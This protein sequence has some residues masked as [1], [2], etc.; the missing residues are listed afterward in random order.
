ML[1]RSSCRALLALLFTALP[2][3]T[4]SMAQSVQKQIA[5][6]LSYD[7]KTLDPAKVDD[8]ASEMVRY[9][10][11]GVL[12]RINRTTQQVEPSLAS[13]WT[14]SADG[15]LVTFYL[16]PGLRFSDGSP[17]TSEDVA[18]SLRRVLDPAT[19]APVAEEFL[20]PRQ[21]QVDTPDPLTVRVHLPQRV[22]T[23][24]RVFDEIA[25]EPANRPSSS[26]I[27]AGPFTLVD[28]K[29]GDFIRLQR[30]PFYWKHDAGGVA[31]PYLNA[32][33]LDI[34]SN[35]EQ[36]QLRFLRGRYQLIDGVTPENYAALAKARPQSMHDLGP[37]LNTEQMWFNQ[38]PGAPLPPWEKV[39]FQSRA[40]RVAVSRAIHRAD[41]ARIA[42]NGHAT[43]AN[44]F[45]SPAN[46]T[47]YD[48]HLQPI[49]QDT[50]GA[51]QMLAQAGF[52]KSGDHL[53]DRGGHP[54]K[55]SILTNAGNRA[56]ERMASMIQQDLA[57][58]GMQVNVVT[59]DFPALIE[60]LMHTQDYEAALLGLSNVDPDPS[61]MM[62]VW[63][64]SSPNHQWNPSEK[65][66]ATDW[67]AEID[68]QMQLQASSSDM[69]VRRKAVDRVQQIVYE[70][71][72]FLYLVYPNQLC[73]VTPEL[74][75]V[76]LSVLQP[77]IV[78][79]IDRMRWKGS[80]P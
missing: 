1:S 9:L 16:R 39:W 49:P 57:A 33:Q 11:G 72:P 55:F 44:G 2:C 30:N 66:P 24:G 73:A 46:A 61:A 48:S 25:I 70:Q 27:T 12:L 10:T 71:Q 80:K 29:R 40:F 18:F 56:R 20:S 54:V 75:G 4:L 22:V 64:S 79:N 60:R 8:Q 74:S 41:L 5:W 50:A 58:L 42:Y 35:R 62:N 3:C 13:R 17:L 78:A 31:L 43:P 37:S 21:V 7:P 77:G 76:T 67:E 34:L 45:I 38:A 23:I 59:L 65:S 63:L 52:R 26:R 53:V 28:Y 68:R 51:L 47:W 6:S 36:E 69:K 15:R 14:L 32:I 19:A